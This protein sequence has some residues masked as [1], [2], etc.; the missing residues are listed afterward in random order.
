[1]SVS[2]LAQD[3]VPAL[4][5]PPHHREGTDYGCWRQPVVYPSDLSNRGRF[6]SYL[7]VD[8]HS[9]YSEKFSSMV[10]IILGLLRVARLLAAT[11]Y[12][13]TEQRTREK[14]CLTSLLIGSSV[15]V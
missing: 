4:D 13:F 15:G 1:M 8:L 7:S 11:V 2:L 9:E 6:H 14:T 3:G 10:P 5:K 12:I